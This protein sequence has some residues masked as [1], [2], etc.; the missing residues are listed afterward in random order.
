MD[1]STLQVASTA[2][3]HLKNAAG[4]PLYDGDK[5]VRIIVHS[6]GSR[7]FATVEARRTARS[8][9]RLN[10]NDGK[11]T[12]PTAEEDLAEVAEDL[13]SVTVAFEHLTYGDKQGAELF[14]AVY[15]DKSLGF[16]TKQVN[17]FLGDWGNFRNAS[18]AT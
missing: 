11:I 3:I 4:E 9:K 7:F 10:E 2:A 13:A 12:A 14:E 6:P 16:I 5:P 18:P 1:A 15:S 8:L 17:K